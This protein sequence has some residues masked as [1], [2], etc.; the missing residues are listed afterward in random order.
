MD[1]TDGR[2]SFD[3]HSWPWPCPGM[4]I[5]AHKHQVP[6][7]ASSAPPDTTQTSPHQE[8]KG[9]EQKPAENSHIGNL[10]CARGSKGNP[11]PALVSFLSSPRMAEIPPEK[12]QKHWRG[13]STWDRESAFRP[14]SRAGK[15]S[16]KGSIARRKEYTQVKS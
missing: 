13:S 5:M 2:V 8:K 1:G 7:P 9:T 15:I 16:V 4:E 3:I 6:R 10:T 11:P 14:V 12:G